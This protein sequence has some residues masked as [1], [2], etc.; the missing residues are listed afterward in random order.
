MIKVF[1]DTMIYIMAPA[2]VKTG[3]PELMHQLVYKLNK[4]GFNAL[5]TYYEIEDKK[6]NNYTP[7]DFKKYINSSI[8]YDKV[9]DDKGNLL[10]FPE[11]CLNIVKKYQNIRKVMWWLSVDNYT[12]NFTFKDAMI[13]DNL[14]QA[15]IN[16][17]KGR[18]LYAKDIYTFDYHLCQSYYALDYIKKKKLDGYYLSDYINSDFFSNK[19]YQKKKQILY[20]PKKGFKFTKKIIENSE[21]LK[22]I[23]IKNMT[24]KQVKELLSSSRVYVDFGNHPGKDRFPREAVISGCCVITGKKGSANFYDDVMILDKYKF[25]NKDKEIKNIIKQIKNCLDNYE[26]LKNDYNSYCERIKG[27]EKVFENDI[28]KIFVKEK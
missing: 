21:E 3:G 27:E 26:L 19:K 14:V 20:N 28:K 18:T 10:V 22:W 12:H 11:T 23:P 7:S 13:K 4:L 24:T 16:L 25:D 1:K 15:M 6:D 2:N 17:I 9:I 5:I 8:T